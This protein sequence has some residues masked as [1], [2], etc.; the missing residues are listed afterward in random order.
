MW[1]LDEEGYRKAFVEMLDY[2]LDQIDATAS[3][4]VLNSRAWHTH[5]NTTKSNFPEAPFFSAHRL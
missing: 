4:P 3:Q 2:C 1:A 5:L